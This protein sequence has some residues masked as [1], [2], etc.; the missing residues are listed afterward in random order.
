MGLGVCAILMV[1]AINAVRRLT[2]GDAG[3]LAYASA[4]VALVGLVITIGVVLNRVGVFRWL[5]H[6]L[7]WLWHWI[8]FSLR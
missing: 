8:W 4:V 6:W 2:A 1:L 3:F 5:G 7:G